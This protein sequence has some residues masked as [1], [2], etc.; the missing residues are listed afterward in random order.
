MEEEKEFSYDD[1]WKKKEE[2]EEQKIKREI[3]EFPKEDPR[4][5]T[6]GRYIKP[7]NYVSRRSSI[8]AMRA[9]VYKD[10]IVN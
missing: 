8:K 2:N 3:E 4:K 5:G 1:F 7:K 9:F 10:R 6:K